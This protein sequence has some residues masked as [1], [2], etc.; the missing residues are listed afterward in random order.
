MSGTLNSIYNNVSYALYIHSIEMARLQEQTTTGSRINR[1]SD[2]P[3]SSYRV[4]ILNSQQTSLENY[5]NNLS[6]IVSTLE[7]SSS[8]IHEIESTI[9]ETKVRL[10]QVIGG[11]Y[12]EETRELTAEGINDLLEQV[13]SLANTKHMEQHLFGG[14]NTSS[15]PYLVERTNGEITGVTYQGS[16]ENR[17]VEVA[18]GVKSSAFYVG[19]DIFHSND[20]SDPVFLGDTGVKAGTGTSNIQGET[21]LTITGSAGNYD[22]SIDDG[23]STFNTDGTDTNL[24]VTD[25]RTGKVLYVD[26]TEIT[27]PGVELVSVPGTYDLFNTLISI[28]GML[29][30]EREL[31]DAELKELQDNSLN[32]LEEVNQLLVQAEVAAGTKIGFLDNLQDSL[33]KLKYDAEDEAT[34]LQ[35]ADIAQI[36]IDLSRREVL[37]EMSLSVAGKLMS[38]TLLDFL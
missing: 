37:Y 20:R 14:N 33:N 32:V 35:E 22:L 28:R 25:S 7:L 17:E 4:A 6:E 8:V 18:P 23:L 26:T 27:G 13:V 16:L 36:A 10:T 34:L 30:N 29:R 15:A 21:W 2:D 19:Q 5:I 38:V 31:S 3:S 11:I 1:P 12:N 24:A 9:T